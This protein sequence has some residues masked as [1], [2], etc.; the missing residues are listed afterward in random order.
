M[1]AEGRDGGTNDVEC[2]HGAVDCSG[3]F[4]YMMGSEDSTI[5]PIEAVD[6]R[7]L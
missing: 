3:T 4:R 5:T 6:A 2:L 7:I 1:E